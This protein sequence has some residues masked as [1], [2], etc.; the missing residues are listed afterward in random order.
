[1]TTA[2][3]PSRST[4]VWNWVKGF[5]KRHKIITVL[6]VLYVLFKVAITPI[7]NPFASDVYVIRGRFPFEQGFELMF[8]Q[9]VYGD[10]PWFRRLCGGL[11][12]ND[13]ICRAG[14]E[15]LKP[16]RLA[17]Q[18]YEIKIYRD[19]YFAGLADWKDEV[20]HLEYKVDDRVNHEKIAASGLGGSENLTCDGSAKASEKFKSEL[21][22]MSQTEHKKYKDLVVTAGKPIGASERL[23][24]FWLYTEL[25][26]M[27]SRE[28]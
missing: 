10:A 23:Q 21:F 25:D 26:A 17:D 6:V 28:K 1:M 27:L 4:R 11:Q 8:R 18:H 9:N 24:N 13:A 20:W 3:T 16:T 5:P 14:Y 2:E 7:K 22:C 12:T 15:D 19:R